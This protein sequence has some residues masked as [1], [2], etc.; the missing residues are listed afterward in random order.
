MG[1]HRAE[2][3]LE[4]VLRKELRFPRNQFPFEQ[5]GAILSPKMPPHPVPRPRVLG[6]GTSCGGWTLTGGRGLIFLPD[7]N[8]PLPANQP[9]RGLGRG[10]ARLGHTSRAVCFPSGRVILHRRVWHSLVPL[11]PVA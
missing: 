7:V 9:T 2:G 1:A 10:P 6:R 8:G 5:G 4:A 3:T 11:G